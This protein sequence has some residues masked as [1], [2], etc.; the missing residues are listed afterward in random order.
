MYQAFNMRRI[1]LKR[2][3]PF[4][5][6]SKVHPS[7]SKTVWEQ[8]SPMILLRLSRCYS[9]MRRHYRPIF[10]PYEDVSTD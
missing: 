4:C 9:C 1:S 8:L 7:E 5:G 6:G 3:C 10:F 2:N